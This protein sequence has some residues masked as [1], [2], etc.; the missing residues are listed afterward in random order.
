MIPV[1]VKPQTNASVGTDRF[2]CPFCFQSFLLSAC[3]QRLMMHHLCQCNRLLK[4]IQLLAFYPFGA[5][6]IFRQDFSSL[7]MSTGAK[8]FKIQCSM[9]PI[10][11]PGSLLNNWAQITDSITC[12]LKSGSLWSRLSYFE[13]LAPEVMVKVMSWGILSNFLI[14]SADSFPFFFQSE[15]RCYSTVLWTTSWRPTPPRPCTSYPQWE[16]RMIRS[17]SQF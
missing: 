5:T 16:S 9:F 10:C 8:L 17:A 11:N 1:S 7:M 14:L 12:D 3:G 13:Q 15:G 4:T 2:A 6:C